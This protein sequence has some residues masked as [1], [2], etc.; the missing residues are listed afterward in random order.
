MSPRSRSV[1]IIIHKEG[2]LESQSFTLRLWIA[3]AAVVGSILLAVLILL[4]AAVYAPIARTAARVPG[5]NRELARLKQENAQVRELATNLERVE[6]RYA[7]L[8]TMLGA[9]VVPEPIFGG[10]SL[11]TAPA[12]VARLP[13]SPSCFEGGPSVPRHWPLGTTG[14]VTRG[15]VT[16]GNSDEVHTG[17]DIAVR[18]GTPIR[19]S[20]GGTIESAGQD[21]EYGQFVRII[22]PDGYISMYG[23]ASRVLVA[24]G[25]S[26]E[27]GEVIG[28]SGSTGRS[29]APHLHFEILHHGR[30]IDPTTVA[31]QECSRGDILIR[32][33]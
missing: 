23:H 7:Q 22:H 25:D 18:R 15:L 2:D 5:L 20:G 8:R 29:T 11:E 3:R 10:D 32:R 30:S 14:I 4:G 6:A 33:G 24:P 9:D 1:T 27:A 12:L 28:L 17:L 21:P 31:S 13:N 19:A 26:V 16:S